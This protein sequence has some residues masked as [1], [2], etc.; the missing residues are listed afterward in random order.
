ML[1]IADHVSGIHLPDWSKLVINP[2]WRCCVPFFKL[3]YW[4]SF[5]LVSLVVLELRLFFFRDWP[6]IWKSEIPPSE[7]SPIFGDWDKLG[8]PSLAQFF[9]IK[10]YYML[11]GYSFYAFWVIKGKPTWGVKLTPATQIMV[12]SSLLS[13]NI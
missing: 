12:K 5:M 7:F 1:S 10:S 8:V 11:Q 13:Q 4:S 9:V 6:E 3:S 2:F